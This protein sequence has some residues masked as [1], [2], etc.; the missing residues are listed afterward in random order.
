MIEISC[1]ES[2]E[3]SESEQSNLI[4]TCDDDSFWAK[5]KSASGF[6]AQCD[7][8]YNRNLPHFDSLDDEAVEYLKLIKI[9]LARG[10]LLSEHKNQWFWEIR[11]YLSLYGHFFPKYDH[12][13]FVEFLLETIQTPNLEMSAISSLISI[14]LA[15]M[16]LVH[17]GK[18]S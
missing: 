17:D 5:R 16:R 8:V 10:N 7:N 3:T 12:I 2:M 9:N 18:L 1:E 11:S 13:L 4:D 6:R 14:L 15:L